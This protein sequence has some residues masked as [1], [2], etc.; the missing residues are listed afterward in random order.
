MIKGIAASQIALSDGRI[1][2]LFY[3]GGRKVRTEPYSLFSPGETASAPPAIQGVTPLQTIRVDVDGTT[4]QTI[5]IGLW[6]LPKAS[7]VA[8]FIEKDGVSG[9]PI[10]ILT[11][12]EPIKSI[13]YFPYLHSSNGLVTLTQPTPQGMRWTEWEL[14]TRDWPNMLDWRKQ[15]NRDVTEPA[16]RSPLPRP[17]P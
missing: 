16:M 11:S 15:S 13:G 12:R 3:G 2:D 4:R 17:R 7:I 5:F 14:N 1:I 10:P 8:G 6:R 9:T